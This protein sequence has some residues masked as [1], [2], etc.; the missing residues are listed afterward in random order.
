MKKILRM[1]GVWASVIPLQLFALTADPAQDM[2]NW[3]TFR[4]EAMGF[5][6][7]YPT[8]W[9][10]RVSQSKDVDRITLEK[11]QKT[12][13]PLRAVEFV[14]QRR[15]NLDNLPI[16]AWYKERVKQIKSQPSPIIPTTLGGRPAIIREG[17]TKMGVFM[18]YYAPLNKTDIL[19][20]NLKTATMGAELDPTY[21]AILS[22]VKFTQ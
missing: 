9:N 20:I 1:V 21:E 18:D 6:V 19:Q 11:P 16:Q 17:E 10:V 4:N 13:S 8:D 5:E 7:Q 14:V 22:T 2:S 3:K 12:G 15:L